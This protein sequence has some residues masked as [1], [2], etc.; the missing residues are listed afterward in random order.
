MQRNPAESY[1]R[2]AMDAAIFGSDARGLTRLCFDEFTQALSRASFAHRNDKSEMRGTSLVRAL[3]ALSGLRAGL[4][5]GNSLAQAFDT[6]FS[7]A[8]RTLRASLVTFDMHSV[9]NIHNDFLELRDVLTG[10]GEGS[11]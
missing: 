5:R 10:A 2:V 7:A 8:D 3:A 4:D 11:V 1:R 6:V 9:Q